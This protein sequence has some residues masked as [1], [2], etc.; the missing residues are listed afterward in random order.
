MDDNRLTYRPDQMGFAGIYSGKID[1]STRSEIS[2]R[3]LSAQEIFSP[4]PKVKFKKGVL[5]DNNLMLKQTILHEDGST[6]IFLLSYY[7]TN[8]SRQSYA[9]F[10]IRMDK[11]DNLEFIRG[12]P[13]GVDFQG[14]TSASD[15]HDYEFYAKDQNTY[16]LTF[17]DKDN[18]EPGVKYVPVREIKGCVLSVTRIDPAGQVKKWYGD[19]IELREKHFVNFKEFV[20][21]DPSTDRMYFFLTRRTLR[22]FW[23]IPSYLKIPLD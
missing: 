22:K 12:I 23:V 14:A 6:D 4:F 3:K 16:I 13:Y 2:L 21:M 8:T 15:D 10:A 18:V 20:Q 7:Y 19:P 1:V 5:E 11:N 9:M 17:E